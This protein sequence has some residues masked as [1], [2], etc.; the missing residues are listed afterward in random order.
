VLLDPGGAKLADFGIARPAAGADLAATRLTETAAIVGTLPYM[1]PEQRA[2]GPLDGRSDLF[3]IGVVL[4]EAATG[5]LPAGAFPPPTRLNPAFGAGFDR[6]VARLLQPEPADRFATAEEAGRA[7]AAALRPASPVRRR[8]GLAIG[9]LAAALAVATPVALRLRA[10]PRAA[11]RRQLAPA[12]PKT[13][14]PETT[15]VVPPP[16]PDT[17]PRPR[18]DPPPPPLIDEGTLGTVTKSGG[19][20]QRPAKVAR[21]GKKAAPAFA[22][23]KGG[24]FALKPKLFEKK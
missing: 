6:A 11:A 18:I 23:S 19:K 24:D 12:A 14:A 8:V 16:P 7:I 15:A 17:D 5:R 22:G 4:Y 13:T 20:R 2:G 3:S 1:S 9:G 10:A 21:G